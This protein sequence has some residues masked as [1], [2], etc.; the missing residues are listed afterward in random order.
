[1]SFSLCSSLGSLTPAGTGAARRTVRGEFMVCL[2][3]TWA[4]E[5]LARWIARRPAGAP[6]PILLHI[7]AHDDLQ[8]PSVQVATERGR[9]AA[10]FGDETLDLHAPA[11]V[12]PFVQRG[13]IGIGGFL[14]PF[15]HTV[16]AGHH[17][18]VHP[19][20]NAGPVTGWLQPAAETVA[21]WGGAYDRPTLTVV[22]HPGTG[23][24][25]YIGTDDLSV[26]AA[27]PAEAPVLVNI[28]LDYF[29]DHY[30]DSQ[31]TRPA[32]LPAASEVR[33]AIEDYVARLHHV[34]AGRVVE[35]VIVACSPGFFPSVF[36]QDALALA[37]E[38]ERLLDPA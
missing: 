35:L 10:P 16:G 34:L 26:I 38:L 32:T 29:C 27:C 23:T 30:D 4:L 33:C 15:W 2:Q 19:S 22:P 6:A 36:W 8:S 24:I 5:A 28:D 11:S 37:S 18:H 12:A 20:N 21:Y 1:M 3:H 14:T 13:L 7:D 25:T 17:I 9:F 31:T